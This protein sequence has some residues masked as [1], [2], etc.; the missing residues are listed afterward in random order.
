MSSKTECSSVDDER[1]D[2]KA[3]E[4]IAGCRVWHPALQV[5]RSSRLRHNNCQND[6]EAR[7]D[8]R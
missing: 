6:S 1:E 4:R 2:D 3:Y 8:G 7:D 5:H